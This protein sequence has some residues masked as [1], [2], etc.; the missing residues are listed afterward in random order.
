MVT[1]A[2][3]AFEEFIAIVVCM[4]LA[5]ICVD[6]MHA[7]ISCK[8]YKRALDSLELKY[9]WLGVTM[10]VQESESVKIASTL[11]HW[12]AWLQ[13]TAPCFI[14]PALLLLGTFS[15]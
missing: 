15:S 7:H 11:N 1:L 4:T 8:G 12:T 5:Y 6:H 10:S 13:S 9:R 14:M 3:L 2:W